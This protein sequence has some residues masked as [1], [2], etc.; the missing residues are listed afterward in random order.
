MMSQMVVKEAGVCQDTMDTDMYL[1]QVSDT[2]D[3]H[4]LLS[5]PSDTQVSEQWIQTGNRHVSGM[6]PSA[7]SYACAN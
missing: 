7:N 4:L 2:C 5:L 6:C 3:R 1:S